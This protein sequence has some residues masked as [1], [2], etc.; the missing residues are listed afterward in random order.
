VE[1]RALLEA[2]L[3]VEVASRSSSGGELRIRAAKFPA[4]KTLKE[5]DFSF[6]R[7]LKKAQ[8]LHLGQLDEPPWVQWRLG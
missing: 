8:V 6:C 7:S 4:R 3:S 1:L 2:L 5:F